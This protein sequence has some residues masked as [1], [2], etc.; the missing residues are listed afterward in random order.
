MEQYGLF[1]IQSDAYTYT[2][3]SDPS[4]M[5]VPVEKIQQQQAYQVTI[6]ASELAKVVTDVC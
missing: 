6:F 5:S 4:S 2:V 3:M 1:K